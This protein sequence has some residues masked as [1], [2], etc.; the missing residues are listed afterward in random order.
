MGSDAFMS[1]IK[2]YLEMYQFDNA[3][4]AELWEALGG[5][6]ITTMMNTWVL[7]AGFPIVYAQ[8]KNKN[9]TSITFKLSQKRMLKY[10]PQV[11]NSSAENLLINNGFYDQDTVDTF[12]DQLWQIPITVER[13]Y[14]GSVENPILMKESSIPSVCASIYFLFRLEFC[15]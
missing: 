14:D 6:T 12:A 1:G 7:Q 4:T 3:D 15:N 13:G 2:E 11:W 5:D 9:D 10:G 8:I